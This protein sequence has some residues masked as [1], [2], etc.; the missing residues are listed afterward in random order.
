M[1]ESNGTPSPSNGAPVRVVVFDLDDT[2]YD[3]LGQCVGAAHREAA[4]AMVD[5]GA[6]ATVE[7]VLET[8]LALAALHPL[9]L[10]DL[11]L[12]HI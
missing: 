8:R 5:A 12:I 10:D 4:R 9:D 7:E 11:S 3:C 2:L 1:S 6:H